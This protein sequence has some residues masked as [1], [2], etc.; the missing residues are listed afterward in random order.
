MFLLKCLKQ[1]PAVHHF[2]VTF[3]DCRYFLF[4][5]TSAVVLLD[6]VL[7][8]CFNMFQMRDRYENTQVRNSCSLMHS[9]CV[10]P[11]TALIKPQCFPSD[12]IKVLRRT[13]MG[14]VLT[15]HGLLY[16]T[17]TCFHQSEYSISQEATTL[18]AGPGRTRTDLPCYS[19]CFVGRILHYP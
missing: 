8:L 14:S 5:E 10:Y 4:H 3:R 9:E 18:S 19:L 1:T 6:F 13:L 2:T 11:I 15:G 16:T 7:H 17:A 12:I